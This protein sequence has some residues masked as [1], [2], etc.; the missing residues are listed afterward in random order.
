MELIVESGMLPENQTRNLHKEASEILAMTVA[1]LK[2][3]RNRKSKIVNFY[4]LVP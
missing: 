3:L 2:T 4:V 1:S